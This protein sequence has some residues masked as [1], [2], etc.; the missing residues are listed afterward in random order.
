M[1]NDV[2]VEYSTEM[3]PEFVFGTTATYSCSEGF[4]LN[5][6]DAVR[7]CG[8]DGNDDTTGLWSGNAPSCD[9]M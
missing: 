3:V 5:G 1:P 9:R 6:G 2:S 8:P 4:G 7:T